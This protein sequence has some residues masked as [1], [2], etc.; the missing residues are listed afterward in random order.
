MEVR[1]GVLLWNKW[2]T[3]WVGIVI[4]MSD[5]SSR[6]DRWMTLDCRVFFNR[7]SVVSGLWEG[8]NERLCAMDSHLKLK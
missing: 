3:L 1:V 8:D 7:F 6:M 5:S 4:Y 2:V